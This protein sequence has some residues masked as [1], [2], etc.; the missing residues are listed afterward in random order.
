MSL[1]SYT[2]IPSESGIELIENQFCFPMLLQ[3]CSLVLDHE[4]MLKTQTI[5]V[6]L[7]TR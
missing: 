6:I 2:L 3:Q 7:K 4:M 1:V 5:Y